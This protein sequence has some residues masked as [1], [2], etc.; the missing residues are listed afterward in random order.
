MLI[1]SQ[2]VSFG[3]IHSVE[4]MFLNGDIQILVA[5]GK[6]S[7][8]DESLIFFVFKIRI[9]LTVYIIHISN[10]GMGSKFTCALSNCERH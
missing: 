3:T 1:F 5:T 10:L 8:L 2:T 4:T 9:Q 6:F 7:L